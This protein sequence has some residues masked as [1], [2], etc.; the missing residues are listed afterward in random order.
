VDGG[1]DRDLR[2]VS[3]VARSDAQLTARLPPPTVLTLERAPSFRI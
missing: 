1:A 2:A 3:P